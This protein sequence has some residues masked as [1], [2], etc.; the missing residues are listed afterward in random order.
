M[1]IPQETIQQIRK[2]ADIVKIISDHTPLHKTNRFFIG[3]CPFH[4]GKTPSLN[5]NPKLQI[6]KCFLCNAGGDVF[7]FVQ[8]INQISFLEAVTRIAQQTNTPPPE[9]VS[10]LIV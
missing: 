6:Y 10:F 5:V 4:K 1:P 2:A 7:T 9:T 3:P 8:Q